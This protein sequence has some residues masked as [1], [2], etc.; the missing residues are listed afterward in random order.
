MYIY[1]YIYKQ[2]PHVQLQHK[3]KIIH[4]TTGMVLNIQVFYNDYLFLN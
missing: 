1:L 3:S 2:F 4:A